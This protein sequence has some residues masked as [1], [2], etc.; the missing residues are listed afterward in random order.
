MPRFWWERNAKHGRNRFVTRLVRKSKTG[1][2]FSIKICYLKVR[3]GFSKNFIIV[4]AFKLCQKVFKKF[5]K[6]FLK[7]LN[8]P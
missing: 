7:S 8:V 1:K 6:T 4:D 5:L 3:S 2:Y